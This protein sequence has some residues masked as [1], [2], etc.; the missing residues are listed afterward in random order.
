MSKIIIPDYIANGGIQIPESLSTKFKKA[1]WDLKQ[2]IIKSP[3][4]LAT[5]TDPGQST[6]DQLTAVNDSLVPSAKLTDDQQDMYTKSLL[7]I[8]HAAIGRAK[9]ELNWNDDKIADPD[10]RNSM[11][12]WNVISY[13]ITNHCPWIQPDQ[14][15]N[16]K[17]HDEKHSGEV[18][19]GAII[20]N[21]MA[22]AAGPEA[23]S[24][25]TALANTMNNGGGGVGVDG[26]G[27]LF[28]NS[29]TTHDERSEMTTSPA[30]SCGGATDVSYAYA[31][32]YMSKTESDWRSLF[33]KHHY[34]SFTCSVV[35]MNLT[36]Y[37]HLWST[38]KNDVYEQIE[39][40]VHN[41][42]KKA[43]LA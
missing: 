43:P 40:W 8:Q 21:V 20:S 30:I 13:V 41:Q 12:W 19:M 7:Y 26:V 15:V 32:V 5:T 36:M 33:V 10:V 22:V 29:K 27:T 17:C 39:P 23:A 35:S 6:P 9:F 2:R 14:Y 42:I 18:D 37:Q 28:W 24:Q 4:V 11:E 16:S 38:V 31:F 34:E 25:I 3:S 1:K